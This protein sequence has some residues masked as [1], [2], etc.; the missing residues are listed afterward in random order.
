MQQY[1]VT[2]TYDDDNTLQEF[3]IVT[4][5]VDPELREKMFQVLFILAVIITII[6]IVLL[7]VIVIVIVIVLLTNGGGISS[8]SSE[9][10]GIHA[11]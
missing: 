9:R 4:P 2:L 8:S 10:S 7:I 3:E 5:D 1:T 11:E 6:I